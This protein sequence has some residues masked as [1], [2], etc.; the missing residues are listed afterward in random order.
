MVSMKASGFTY[1]PSLNHTREDGTVDYNFDKVKVTDFSKF[2]FSST[3]K[4][5][6]EGWNISVQVA[7]K[8]YIYEQIYSPTKTYHSEKER[9]KTMNK[10]TMITLMT[11][12]LWHG[13]YLAYFITFFHWALCLQICGE[14][15][16]FRT[17]HKKLKH[18]WEKYPILDV[19]ENFTWQYAIAYFGAASPL[20]LWDKIKVY[21]AETYYIPCIILYITFFL[22]MKMNIL[23]KI[24]AKSEGRDG[25]HLK[26]VSDEKKGP[27]SD[28]TQTAES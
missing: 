7:L 18:L 21:L 9:K 22:V 3:L 20:L 28:E 26:D 6:A 15:W 12:G 8:R 2:F 17:R 11:S 23:S 4:V 27:Q 13:F 10:A 25:K 24:L 5:K 1:N 16:K 19:L 14:F